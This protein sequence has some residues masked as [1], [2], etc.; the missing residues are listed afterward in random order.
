MFA[1]TNQIK[2]EHCNVFRSSAGLETFLVFM[3]VCFLQMGGMEAVITGLTDD[4][5]ILKRNRKLFTFATA[6]GTFLVAL[7]CITNVSINIYDAS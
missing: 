5:K 3:S 4:F 6:F 7:F 1:L 2:T